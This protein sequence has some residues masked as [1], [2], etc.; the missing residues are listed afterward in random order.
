MAHVDQG[1]MMWVA[2]NDGTYWP[3]KASAVAHEQ[4]HDAPADPNAMNS[5][6]AFQGAQPL[7]S[8]NNLNPD[9][10]PDQVS[11]IKARS[12]VGDLNGD[13]VVDDKDFALS[14]LPY[15]TPISAGGTATQHVVTTGTGPNSVTYRPGGEQVNNMPVQDDTV[16]AQSG[17]NQGPSAGTTEARDAQDAAANQVNG[18]DNTGQEQHNQDRGAFLDAINN[19]GYDTSQSQQTRQVQQQAL[20]YQSDLLHRILGFDPNAY[21]QQ[22]ADNSLARSTALARSGGGTAGA[23]QA[24]IDTALEQAPA[25]YAQGQQMADTLENQRLN[26]AQSAVGKFADI[27]YGVRTQD[28]DTEQ[29]KTKVSQGIADEYKGLLSEDD[30]ENQARLTNFVNV[31]QTLIKNTLGWAQLDETTREADLADAFKYANLDEDWN[32]FEAELKKKY[33]HKSAFQSF[34]DTVDTVSAT[35]TKAAPAVAAL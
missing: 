5:D 15:G 2:D 1:V 33:P 30:T 21:A 8:Q 17:P 4:G 26:S 16:P 13:G 11:A 32:K 23:R 9:L 28:T 35:V 31:Y 12:V 7:N 20:G 27:A 3:D 34:M 18:A 24:N 14:K 19:I 10:T 6:L 22:F 29:F 25:L